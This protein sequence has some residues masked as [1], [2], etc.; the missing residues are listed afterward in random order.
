[1]NLKA[2]RAAVAAAA[3]ANYLAELFAAVT[4]ETK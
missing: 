3:R 1:V 2:Y 4:K